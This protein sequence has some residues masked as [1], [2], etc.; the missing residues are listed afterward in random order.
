[1]AHAIGRVTMQDPRGNRHAHELRGKRDAWTSPSRPPCAGRGSQ[2]ALAGRTTS[3]SVPK[4]VLPMSTLHWQDTKLVSCQCRV[5]TMLPHAPNCRP[6]PDPS[7]PNPL[8]FRRNALRATC[9]LN[10]L[11]CLRSLEAPSSDRSKPRGP[12]G[13]PAGEVQRQLVRNIAGPRQGRR[14]RKASTIL[15]RMGR[16][17]PRVCA[18]SATSGAAAITPERWGVPPGNGRRAQNKNRRP[19]S[20]YP[21][22]PNVPK[23]TRHKSGRGEP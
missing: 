3:L 21:V 1:M 14:C 20:P 22:R 2:A 19:N 12:V 17:D 11:V 4:S 23:R 13:R 7:H 9:T 16:V 8:A 6:P 15:A 10:I 18:P 5:A